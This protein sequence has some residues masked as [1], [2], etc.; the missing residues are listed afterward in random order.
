MAPEVE[1]PGDQGLEA[2]E[3]HRYR[4]TTFSQDVVAPAVR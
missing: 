4:P 1:S 3:T 2:M